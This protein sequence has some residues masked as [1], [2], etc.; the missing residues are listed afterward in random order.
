MCPCSRSR[1]SRPPQYPQLPTLLPRRH[2]LPTSE[3]SLPTSEY[4][5]PTSEY[6]LP[7]SEYSVPTSEYSPGPEPHSPRQRALVRAARVNLAVSAAS[8]E[9][10]P[11]R[12]SPPQTRRCARPATKETGSPHA[13]RLRR[14]LASPR[15]HLHRDWAHPRRICARTGLTPGHVCTRT[16]LTP[17]TSAPGLGWG[18]TWAAGMDRKS[19]MSRWRISIDTT[20]ALRAAEPLR[21][22]KRQVPFLSMPSTLESR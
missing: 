4:S 21:Q 1:Y 16:G 12:P 13:A 17:A 8:P 6:A 14:D 9:A 3:Y 11:R 7:T 22:T 10:P 18:P 19:A 15:P 20:S 2:S 5:L